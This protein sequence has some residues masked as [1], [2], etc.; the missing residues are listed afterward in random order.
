MLPLQ[1]TDPNGPVVDPNNPVLSRELYETILHYA[2]IPVLLFLI[3]FSWFL[4]NRLMNPE[5]RQE[6]RNR[7][8]RKAVAEREALRAQ[9]EQDIDAP[10]T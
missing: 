9:R 3:W 7:E 8:I 4:I 5:R 10:G 6:R 1:A 2:T